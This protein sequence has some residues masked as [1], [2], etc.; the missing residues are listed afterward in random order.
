MEH[1]FFASNIAPANKIEFVSIEAIK[2][3]VIANLGVA[4]LPT[5]AVENDLQEGRVIQLDAHFFTTPV[6]THI[7]WHEDKH[8]SKPLQAFI[9]DTRKAFQA[10]VH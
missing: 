9:D 2:Q 7:A 3:C 5:M 6:Y 10:L 4:L 1:S 8:L